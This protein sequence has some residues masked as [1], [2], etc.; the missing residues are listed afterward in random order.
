MSNDAKFIGEELYLIAQSCQ[1]SVRAF[2]K[3]DYFQTGY[4]S[5]LAGYCGIAS[6]FFKA[7]AKEFGHHLDIVEGRY[8][9]GDG[10]DY[11]V[12]HCW[13]MLGDTIIDLT[14][15][16]FDPKARPIYITDADDRTYIPFNIN[17]DAY[18]SLKS[19]WPEDQS[20][21]SCKHLLRPYVNRTIKKIAA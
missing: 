16:Q 14:A 1:R 4:W 17:L 19:L 20:P 2:A 13:N 9:V 7:V 10:C 6:Y 12:N 3:K 8:E 15:R 5:D 18:K 21:F 11:D